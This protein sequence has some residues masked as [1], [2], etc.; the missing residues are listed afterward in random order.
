MTTG[1]AMAVPA[2]TE[3]ERL[4]GCPGSTSPGAIRASSETIRWPRD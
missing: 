1:T 2:S 4:P 3:G